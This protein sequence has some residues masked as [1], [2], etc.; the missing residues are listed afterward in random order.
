METPGED[1]YPD[2]HDKGGL[3]P[4]LEAKA[5]SE[6][7]DLG[8]VTSPYPAGPG[9]F[10]TAQ[11]ESSRGRITV[12]LDGR[13]RTFHLGI[14]GEG[15]SW[16]HGATDDFQ[17]LVEALAAWRAGMRVADFTDRFPFISPGRLAKVHEADDPTSA[18]WAWLLGAEGYEVERPLLKAVHDDGRFRTLFPTLSHGTLRLN[19]AGGRQGA[20]ELHIT[21]LAGGGYQVEDTVGAGP[22]VVTS[23]PKAIA[24]AAESLTSG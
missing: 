14:Q 10:S 7:I 20:R 6:V 15:F 18:Q 11:L 13:S 5:K 19:W 3:V 21:P 23:L 17:E 8:T 12:E 4:A 24:A 22:R 1:L 16:A 2:I 9:W